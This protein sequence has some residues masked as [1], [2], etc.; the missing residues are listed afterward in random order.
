MWLLARHGTRWPTKSKLLRVNS[1]GSNL[2]THSQ[3]P[4][5]HWV[6]KQWRSPVEDKVDVAGRLHPAG[7]N[8]LRSLGERLR[9]RFPSLISSTSASIPLI[10]TAVKRTSESAQAFADGFLPQQSTSIITAPKDRDPLLRPFDMSSEYITLE[11]TMKSRLKA[12]KTPYWCQ[13]TKKI[14]SRLNLSRLVSPD[15]VDDLW[16]LLL[17]EGGLDGEF[18]SAG[19]FD[20]E[21]ISLLEW[22]DDVDLYVRRGPYHPLNYRIF[23]PLLQDLMRSLHRA[24]AEG[25]E[26]PRMR[27]LFAHCETLIPFVS[28]LDLFKHRE[29]CRSKEQCSELADSDSFAQAVPFVED[30]AWRSAAISPYGSN[31]LVVLYRQESSSDFLIRLYY[32]EQLVAESSLSV[33]LHSLHSKVSSSQK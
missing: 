25:F 9:S 31:L 29:G 6:V 33:F 18:R 30:R 7:F 11:M 13:L 10:A 16:Q 8:E 32:N 21:D 1:L 19:L 26:G 12:W 5:D 2:F 14:R 27:L 24:A 23:E 4:Q 22:L 20:S 17:V 15:E 3:L 28:L